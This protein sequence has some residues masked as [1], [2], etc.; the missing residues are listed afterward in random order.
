MFFKKKNK[1][2]SDFVF[3][4][5]RY[6]A[7]QHVYDVKQGKTLCD[8]GYPDPTDIEIGPAELKDI[9]SRQHLGYII[10]AKC[11]ELF[12]GISEEEIVAARPL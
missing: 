9:I 7:N 1:V 12:T 4:K 8:Y 5:S 11:G 10:C 3:A 2:Q 6:G